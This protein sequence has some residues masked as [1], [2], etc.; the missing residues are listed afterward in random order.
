MIFNTVPFI[1]P[2]LIDWVYYTAFSGK[3]KPT[4]FFEL[5][6]NLT[7]FIHSLL[8]FLNYLIYLSISFYIIQFH[9]VFLYKKI[10]LYGLIPCSTCEFFNFF[11]QFILILNICQNLILYKA[12]SEIPSA[13]ASR[14]LPS[15]RFGF[16]ALVPTPEKEVVPTRA[17]LAKLSHLLNRLSQK[18]SLISPFQLLCL[19]IVT[20]LS[21]QHIQSQIDICSP[22]PIFAKYIHIHDSQYHYEKRQ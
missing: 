19:S 14:S 4:F 3:C 16:I 7:I 20:Y 2:K 13:T 8:L 15:F 9:F 18:E 10:Y 1:Q 21:L 12:K 22:M 5:S 11:V 6:D 17:K